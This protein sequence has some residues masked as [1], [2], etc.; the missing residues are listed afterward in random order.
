M[1]C[2]VN[3]ALLWPLDLFLYIAS[4]AAA[5]SESISIALFGY[6]AIPILVPTS[7][8]PP[9]GNVIGCCSTSINFCAITSASSGEDKPVIINANSSPPKRASMSHSRTTACQR[10]ATVLSTKSPA[11][12]P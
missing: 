2:S 5:I 9:V 3:V 7:H 4:S 10:S 8:N 1:V 6:I 12:C 11:S